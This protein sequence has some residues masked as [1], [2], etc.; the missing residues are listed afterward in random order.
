M[1]NKL[2]KVIRYIRKHGVTFTF[3]AVY[4]KLY[5]KRGGKCPLVSVV[6]P[7]YNAESYL[8]QAIGSLLNQSMKH[9]EIIAVDDGSTDSS[10][11]ILNRFAASDNR[12]RV[13]TQKNQYAGVARNLG[14]SHAKGEY[15]IFLDSDD[16]FEKNLVKDTYFKAKMDKA[17]VVLFGANYF[18]DST[19]KKSKGKGVLK[20]EFAP[21][22]Q[23][24]SYKDCPDT[25]YQITS[26]SPWTKLYRADFVKKSGLQFQNLHNANDVFFTFSALS[27]AERIT[28][29][30]KA[31][32]N[33]RT[34]QKNNLQS[35]SKRYF[36]EA[37]SAWHQKLIEL[38]RMDEV[39]KSYV[40]RA[41]ES[42]L[43][44]LRAVKNMDAKKAIFEKLK[45]EAFESLE[46][47]G[48]EEEYY[49]NKKNYDHMILI[50][51]GSFEQYLEAQNS[52]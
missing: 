45:N 48:H 19:G 11:E 12:V 14:L 15:I 8:E 47:Y 10:L 31:L 28:V 44:N 46:I 13:Y 42:C 24:F 29:L 21:S 50:K 16:F 38:G 2:K 34:G 52:K 17:D 26:A 51:T 20:K 40:N 9:I 5:Q 3:R 43:Y 18:D 41:L 33:Y 25:I 30:D 32:V 6:M 37:Y 35:S 49:H 22:K 7:V 1:L 39:R 36:Y 23:P 4:V 27:V